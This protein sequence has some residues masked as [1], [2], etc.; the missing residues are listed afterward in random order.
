MKININARDTAT[1]IPHCMTIQG[2]QQATV[3]DDHLQWLRQHIRRGR[4]ESTN[5][6]PQ[7]VRLCWILRDGIKGWMALC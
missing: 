3:S 2:T 7:E 5:K 6:V 1:D 4:P